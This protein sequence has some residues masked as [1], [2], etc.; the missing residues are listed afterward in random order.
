METLNNEIL[1]DADVKI[2]R[3][4]CSRC[5]VVTIIWSVVLIAAMIGLTIFLVHRSLHAGLS[6]RVVLQARK[7]K[8]DIESAMQMATLFNDKNGTWLIGGGSDL[9]QNTS[10]PTLY[11]STDDGETWTPV[12][13]GLPSMFSLYAFQKVGNDII[14]LVPGYFLRSKDYGLTWNVTE[15]ENTGMSMSHGDGILLVSKNPNQI[16]RSTDNGETFQVINYTDKDGDNLRAI[17]YA[18][19]QTFYMGVGSEERED[20]SAR[21]FKTEDGGLTWK[22]IFENHSSTQDYIV[23]SVFA[24]DENTVLIGAG[25]AETPDRVIYRSTNGGKNWTKVC[26]ITKEFDEK[27]TIVRSFYQGHDG[28]LYACLDCSYRSSSLWA[29]EPDDAKN[30]MIIVSNDKG[31][32]WSKFTKTGTKRLYWISET[33]DKKFIA[34]TGEYGQVLK[35]K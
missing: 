29:D 14:G 6:W 9:H 7:D 12:Y 2:E 32:T 17:S 20:G 1:L 10:K 19:K 11:R 5:T 31:K 8:S 18:G 13:V 23:F 15:M 4:R 22:C 16:Y 26:N 27:L 24:Y 30:S 33:M 25:S 21:V 34:A 35:S 3:P 28:K